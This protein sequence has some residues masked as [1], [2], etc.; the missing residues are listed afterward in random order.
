MKEEL[1][2]HIYGEIIDQVTRLDEEITYEAINTAMEEAA[3]Y[4][5]NKYDMEAVYETEGSARPSLLM[6][7]VKDI[8]VWHLIALAN[9]NIDLE[10][11][12]QRYIDAIKWLKDAQKGVVTLSLP[13]VGSGDTNPNDDDHVGREISW[14]SNHKRR[15]HF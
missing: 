13:L 5:R 15:N 7:R 6:S 9:P 2:S 14:S 11:R 10:L 4:L 3:G 12:E 1:E 8:A